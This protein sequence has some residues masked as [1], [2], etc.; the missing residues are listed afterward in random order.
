MRIDSLKLKGSKHFFRLLQLLTCMTLLTFIGKDRSYADVH[1]IT[2]DA[3]Q[4]ILKNSGSD[5]HDS[6]GNKDIKH[7]KVFYKKG[8]FG[9]WPAKHGLYNGRA[10]CREREGQ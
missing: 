10:S 7:I 6:T 8:E 5:T 4:P 9:G 3:R 2:T 1:C